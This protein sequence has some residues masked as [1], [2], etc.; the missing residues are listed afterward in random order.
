MAKDART[1]AEKWAR[2]LSGATEDIRQGVEQTTVNP[3]QEAIK[4]KEKLKKRWLEAIDGGKWE[5]RLS[6][7]SLEEWKA[8]MLNKGLARIPQ[9]AEDAKPKFEDFMNQLLPYIENV[10]RKVNAMPDTT[11]EDRINRMVTFIREMAKFK[12]K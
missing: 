8:K 1:I 2:R 5:A 6:K 9:G 4:K 10:K 7:V 11:L 12:A 3:A